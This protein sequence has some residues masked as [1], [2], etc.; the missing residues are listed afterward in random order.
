MSADSS[1]LFFI[2][3]CVFQW[4]AAPSL[5]RRA[6][7]PS[8]QQVIVSINKILPVA[9]APAALTTLTA[10]AVARIEATGQCLAVRFSSNS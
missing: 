10:T 8:D 4:L 3:M 9:T 2:Y 1:A 5:S 7:K 6:L